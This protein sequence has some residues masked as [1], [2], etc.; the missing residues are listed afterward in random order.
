MDF[1]THLVTYDEYLGGG[2]RQEVGAPLPADPGSSGGTRRF[3]PG[4]AGELNGSVI[5]EP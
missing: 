5:T 3:H 2:G 1:L 4:P